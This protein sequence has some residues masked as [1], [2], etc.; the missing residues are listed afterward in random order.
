MANLMWMIAILVFS[1]CADMGSPGLQ[2][3]TV[4]GSTSR[5]F[6]AVPSSEAD[7]SQ[8]ANLLCGDESNLVSNWY[9][10]QPESEGRKPIAQRICRNELTARTGFFAG[11]QL[12]FSVRQETRLQAVHRD[13]AREEEAQY[14]DCRRL[15]KIDPSGNLAMREGPSLCQ[16][17]LVMRELI[18]EYHKNPSAFGHQVTHCQQGIRNNIDCTTDWQV[19]L[20]Q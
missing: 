17:A 14:A 12:E 16:Q 4:D 19:P 5:I 9:M 3:G 20:I 13:Q 2:S 1:G 8:H 11:D 7:A 10:M 15:M 18:N 6:P